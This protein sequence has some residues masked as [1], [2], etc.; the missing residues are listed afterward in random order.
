MVTSDRD[1]IGGKIDLICQINL[2]NGTTLYSIYEMSSL[3]SWFV[4]DISMISQK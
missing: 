4:S 1:E 2:L 3:Q